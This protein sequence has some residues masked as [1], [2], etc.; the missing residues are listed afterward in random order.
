MTAFKTDVWAKWFNV[1]HIALMIAAA[2]VLLISVM[3]V[4]HKSP[5]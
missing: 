1:F 2:V 3:T 5:Y 4:S